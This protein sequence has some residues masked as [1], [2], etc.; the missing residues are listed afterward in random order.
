MGYLLKSKQALIDEVVVYGDA[1]INQHRF[2]SQQEIYFDEASR[3]FIDT[4]SDIIF[5]K[6]IA[7]EVSFEEQ[8]QRDIFIR[9][10]NSTKFNN[11]Q[12]TYDSRALKWSKKELQICMNTTN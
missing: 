9:L 2:L 7:K 1:N 8:K 3:G 6:D 10:F 12:Q 11:V 4:D 5:E